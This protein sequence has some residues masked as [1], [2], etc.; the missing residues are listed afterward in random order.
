LF[1]TVGQVRGWLGVSEAAWA[2]ARAELGDNLAAVAVAVILE[3]H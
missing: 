1:E 3:K 2:E